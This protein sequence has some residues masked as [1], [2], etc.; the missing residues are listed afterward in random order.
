VTDASAAPRRRALAA[1]I[2]ATVLGFGSFYSLLAAVP[3]MAENQGGRSA[4]GLATGA[5]MA[6]TVVTQALTPWLLR[7]AATRTVFVTGLVALGAPCFLYRLSDDVSLLLIVTAAR[8]VGFG[9][10]AVMGAA[11]CVHFASPQHHGR[12]LGIY[13]CMIATTGIA[14]PPIGVAMFDHGQADELF[15]IAAFLALAGGA[16]AN[17]LPR[18][19]LSAPPA[20]ALRALLGDRRILGALV[21]FFP[22]A[23]LFGAVYSFMVLLRPDVGSRALLTYGVAMTAGRLAAGATVDRI[24]TGIGSLVDGAATITAAA[25]V[26]IA[27]FEQDA[28]TLLAA[29]VAGL[30]VGVLGNWTLAVVLRRAGASHYVTG[31]TA[32]NLCIDTGIGVGSAGLAGVAAVLG[33]R[34]V[35]A[36]AAAAFVLACLA[37]RWLNAR[38]PHISGGHRA[39]SAE[40]RYS[41]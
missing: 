17:L 30:G 23:M 18:R 13:G 34:A 24:G 26:A 38:P 11:L 1:S 27:V 41:L 22:A 29:F 9:I 39:T 10:V 14:M 2:V 33:L 32:W 28:V 5:L 16:A 4:P 25:A 36:L 35:F 40:A 31:S 12:I 21:V 6:T 8:G 7:R 20:G 19:S 37:A 3:L 15:L